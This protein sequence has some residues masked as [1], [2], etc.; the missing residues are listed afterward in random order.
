MNMDRTPEQDFARELH[1]REYVK[2]YG[3]ADAKAEFALTL[4]RAREEANK[5]QQELA[6]AMGRS[7][8]YI[9]KLESGDANPTLSTVGSLLSVLGRRLKM[10]TEPLLPTVTVPSGLTSETTEIL[11]RGPVEGFA[12]PQ[13]SDA[14]SVQLGRGLIVFG[15]ASGAEFEAGAASGYRGAKVLAGSAER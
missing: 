12:K 11:V 3:A 4:A 1:D 5:T 6:A 2:L 7:Q 14:V 10:R 15:N 13:V 8:P 9:A